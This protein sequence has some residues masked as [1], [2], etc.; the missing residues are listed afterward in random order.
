MTDSLDP[1]G[2]FALRLDH[3]EVA[4]ELLI[5]NVPAKERGAVIL[6]DGFADALIYRRLQAL[7]ALTERGWWYRARMPSYPKRLRE[8]ASAEFHLRLKLV[9]DRTYYD[10][11]AGDEDPFIDDI[12]ATVLQIA[13]TYRNDAYHRDKHNA[14]TIGMIGRLSFVAASRLFARSQPNGVGIGVRDHSLDRLAPYDIDLTIGFLELR[15]AAE[16][17]ASRLQQ[18]LEVEHAVLAAD[19]AD[20]IEFRLAGLDEDLG[21]LRTSGRDVDEILSWTELGRLHGADEELLRLSDAADPKTRAEKAGLKS[22][23]P[24][25]VEEAKDAFLLY[26]RRESELRE[27]TR[28]KANGETLDRLKEEPARLRTVTRTATLLSKY[29][30]ADRALS[31]IEECAAEALTAFD[32]AVQLDLDR[33][34]GK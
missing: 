19:L 27:S 33:A 15:A 12:Q 30:E 23:P 11:L 1:L 13:H 28:L 6:L 2:E 16:Q 5:S 20:D 34:R 31:W 9:R 26:R 25:F 18:G 14:A 29:H 10:E 21:H 22:V 7:Y 3:L 17:V 32:E 24:D 4:H 8:K